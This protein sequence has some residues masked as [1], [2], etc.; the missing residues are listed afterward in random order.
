MLA[1]TRLKPAR[2]VPG[3]FLHG[4]S[5]FPI[6]AVGKQNSRRGAAI[7]YWHHQIGSLRVSA[8]ALGMSASP[9][10]SPASPNSRQKTE[11]PAGRKLA[12]A[13][14]D[15]AQRQRSSPE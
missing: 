1:D 13:P 9:T 11:P 4:G 3:N 10:G 7:S 14:V 6:M 8:P 2:Q 5:I 15:A 12:I